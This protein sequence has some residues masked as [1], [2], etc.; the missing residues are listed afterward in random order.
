MKLSLFLL[1]LLNDGH[2]TLARELLVFN[3]A[4][5]A[6]AL[7]LLKDLYYRDRM[8]MPGI[9]PEFD[10]EAALWAARYLYQVCQFILL[11]DLDAELLQQNLTDFPGVRSVEAIYSADLALRYLPDLFRLASGLSPDD[12]LVANM[13]GIAEQW[14]FSSVGIAGLE[15]SPDAVILGNSCLRQAYID[16]VISYRDLSR[17]KGPAERLLL[18]E[19]LGAHGSQLWPELALLHN[20]I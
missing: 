17:L 3:A 9:A 6:D 20:E 1:D 11:R 5:D 12:P 2:V 4:E 18:K 8:A 19:V 7:V 10:G 13:R 14:V 16:R 15:L